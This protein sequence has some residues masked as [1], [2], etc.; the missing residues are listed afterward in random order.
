MYSGRI[1][2]ILIVFIFTIPFV[3][4]YYLSKDYH[5]GGELQTSNYGSFINPIVNL[6]QTSLNDYS[7]E[8]FIVNQHLNKWGLIYRMSENCSQ[9]CEEEIY[10]I[11]QVNI[12]LGK[13]MNRL[14]RVIVLSKSI[15]DSEIE[16]VVAK[17]PKSIIVKNN[18]ST[19]IDEI[20][21]ITN[22]HVLLLTDPLGNVILGYDQDFEGKKLLKD[23]KKLL[24]LSKIG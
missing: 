23:I 2:F 13:D 11:R 15:S 8:N 5:A 6:S 10:L 9:K 21:K 1:K 17:Y 24:K 7:G 19:F 14:Q 16:E 22:R 20:N 4:S 12:A 18:S 3:I